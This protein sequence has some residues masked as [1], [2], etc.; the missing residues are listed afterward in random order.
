[1]SQKQKVKKVPVSKILYSFI[2]K[3]APQFFEIIKKNDDLIKPY[4]DL[5]EKMI[6][7]SKE[8]LFFTAFYADLINHKITNDEINSAIYG[9]ALMRIVDDTYDHRGT[10]DI[11]KFIKFTNPIIN[12]TINEDSSE[13]KNH[14][15]YNNQKEILQQ[16][17]TNM[18]QLA[19][20]LYINLIDSLKNKEKQKRNLAICLQ[21]IQKTQEIYLE[22]KEENKLTPKILKKICVDKG[23]YTVLLPGYLIDSDMPNLENDE[24]YDYFKKP[25]D[26]L[27][28]ENG[29]N[30]NTSY[31]KR[32]FLYLNGGIIQLLDDKRDKDEDVDMGITTF[33]STNELSKGEEK[34]LHSRLID[35]FDYAF[36]K[37]L[38]KL[39][40]YWYFINIYGRYHALLKK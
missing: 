31:W 16:L 21:R 22:K 36:K 15:I 10:Q 40:Y 17:Y 24:L 14:P 9:G 37:D 34:R 6:I 8:S 35:V 5:F 7:N 38:P 4:E 33:A 20:Y 18:D 27:R 25:L 39:K 23:G 2:E 32:Q 11:L 26:Q 29:F 1:M 30:N 13:E 3:H 19:F 12:S 28:K